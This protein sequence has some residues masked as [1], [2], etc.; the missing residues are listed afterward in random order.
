MLPW[1]EGKA[2]PEQSTISVELGERLDDTSVR[3]LSMLRGWEQ[4][5]VPRRGREA[6]L[7][8]RN[9]QARVTVDVV[10]NGEQGDA[11]IRDSELLRDLRTRERRSNLD[12]FVRYPLE[13]QGIVDLV[14]KGGS[15]VAIDD[16]RQRVRADRC[17]PW[18]LT[19]GI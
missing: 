10:V 16:D 1:N 8:R 2:H 14:C 4:S 3:V 9:N 13:D 7:Q 17:A 11:P 18:E 12:A 15:V 19:R 5:S 6:T